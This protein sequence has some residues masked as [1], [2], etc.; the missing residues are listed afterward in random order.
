MPALDDGKGPAQPERASPRFDVPSFG[1]RTR[2]LARAGR[3]T[4]SK[5][6]ARPNEHGMGRN[7]LE[8]RTPETE[9]SRCDP[10]R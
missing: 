6:N 7:L 10:K 4:V 1:E 3:A 9:N 2:H 8:P 5:A